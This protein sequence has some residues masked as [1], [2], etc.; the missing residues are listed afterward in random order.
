[1]TQPAVIWEQSFRDATA[2]FG[3]LPALLLSVSF[4]FPLALYVPESLELKRAE[5]TSF[6]AKRGSLG[7]K[8]QQ[9]SAIGPKGETTREFALV[10]RSIEQRAEVH[11]VPSP[12]GQASPSAWAKR[13]TGNST[14]LQGQKLAIS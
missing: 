1:M 14:T 10:R 3:T 7:L 5:P 4:E 13:R 8:P 2:A 9:Q 12:A 11:P 6:S